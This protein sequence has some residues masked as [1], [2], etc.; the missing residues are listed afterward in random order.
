M[1]HGHISCRPGEGGGG[2]CSTCPCFHY[3]HVSSALTSDCVQI[4]ADTVAARLNV[5]RGALIQA[6]TAGGAAEKA[7][8]LPTRRGLSGIVAGACMRACMRA[9]VHMCVHACTCSWSVGPAYG[10]SACSDPPWP[11]TTA[12]AATAAARAAATAPTPN[13]AWPV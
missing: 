4:A 2:C 1:N 8:L 6:V 10:P 12:T 5:G 9:C 3:R 7:G 13:V 11:A